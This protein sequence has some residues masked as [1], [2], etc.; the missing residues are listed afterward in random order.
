MFVFNNKKSL[1]LTGWTVAGILSWAGLIASTSVHTWKV[2][3]D[4]LHRLTQL[5]NVSLKAKTRELEVAIVLTN[6][7]YTW[8]RVAWIDL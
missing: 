6:T 3:A 8:I 5:S 4:I 7:V 1:G 2:I